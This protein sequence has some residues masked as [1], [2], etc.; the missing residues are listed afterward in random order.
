MGCYSPRRVSERDDL[1]P[2]TAFEALASGRRRAVVR[3]LGDAESA[4]TVEDLAAGIVASECADVSDRERAR[5]DLHH[6]TL[7]KLDDLGIVAYDIETHRVE[8]EQV[9]ERLEPLLSYLEHKQTQ[10]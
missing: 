6:N 10:T 7:P 4:L 8:L 3:L 1:S 9:A 2:D 5:I